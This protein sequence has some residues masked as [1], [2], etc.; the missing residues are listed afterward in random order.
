[1]QSQNQVIS[2]NRAS[3]EQLDGGAC[4]CKL[5]IHD[6]VH[7]TYV[8]DATVHTDTGHTDFESC[9]N[10]GDCN[11]KL[12]V[13]QFYKSLTMFCASRSLDPNSVSLAF[14]L[15]DQPQLQ[16]AI[17]LH[18]DKNADNTLSF[19]R[20]VGIYSGTRPVP[21]LMYLVRKNTV[22]ATSADSPVVFNEI[23]NNN[24]LASQIFEQLHAL[25]TNNSW[26]QGTIEV[27][28]NAYYSRTLVENH[29]VPK[30]VYDVQFCVKQRAYRQ[31]H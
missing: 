25:C 12:L 2:V 6:K 11:H 4:L 23:F 21:V 13:E 17:N 16:F 22:G 30:L 5:V 24:I 14:E 1:M 27:K 18:A 7:N 19:E 15:D 10:A 3:R 31:T 29:L 20:S 26:I 8:A 28:Q 9:V